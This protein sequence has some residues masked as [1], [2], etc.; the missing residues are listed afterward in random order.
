MAT[1]SELAKVDQQATRNI[2]TG[3]LSNQSRYPLVSRHSFRLGCCILSGK[4]SRGLVLY[5]SCLDDSNM[6]A[7][8]TIDVLH[9][10]RSIRV[11]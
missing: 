6:F 2:R 8:P 7:I 11:C 3:N 1:C 10:P 9:N 4:T 5:C